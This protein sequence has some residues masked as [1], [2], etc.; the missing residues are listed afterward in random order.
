MTK[1]T[2]CRQCLFR[3]SAYGQVDN[4]NINPDWT[5]PSKGRHFL[6]IG[7]A[8]IMFF[9]PLGSAVSEGNR[10]AQFR[11]LQKNRTRQVRNGSTPF[12]LDGSSRG[13]IEWSHR[14]L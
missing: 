8:L 11:I 4:F 6:Q 13:P 2:K 14:V 5:F 12:I 9:L 1:I 10:S 7:T 3:G